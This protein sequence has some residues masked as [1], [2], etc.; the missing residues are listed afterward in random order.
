MTYW[1]TVLQYGVDRYADDLLAA[2][3]AGS[4]RPT[5][6]RRGRRLDRREQPDRAR[7]R[8]PRGADLDR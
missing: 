8:L 6:P 1:N 2:G 5:S 7:P 4:S 3:G